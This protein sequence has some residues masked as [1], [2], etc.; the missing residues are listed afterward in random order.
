[1]CQLV[2]CIAA[3]Q[4]HRRLPLRTC[5]SQQ[6]PELLYAVQAFEA[7]QFLALHTTPLYLN[8]FFINP[9]YHIR[10]D[11]GS[12]QDNNKMMAG[13]FKAVIGMAPAFGNLSFC[14]LF[15]L[16]CV[17]VSPSIGN[18]KYASFVID[19]NT[20][21]VLHATNADT[22][23]YP[24]SLTKMM[25][26]YMIFD[27]LR[28]GKWTLNTK[29]KITRRAAIQPASKLGLKVGSTITVR[30]AILALV[31]K[32]ANDVAT[33]VA[34][35]AAG[36]ERA[37]A[38]QMTSKARE[39]G[40]RR[41]TF[42]NASGLPHRGQ[43]STARDMATLARSLIR[44]HQQY[45]HFFSTRKFNFKDRTYGNHNKLLA[46]YDGTD[47]IK[48]G[49][50]NASGYNL[51]A[52]AVR[53]N[54]RLIGVVFGGRSS[55]HRNR[56]MKILLDKGYGIINGTRQTVI[57]NSQKKPKDPIVAGVPNRKNRWGIQVGAYAK[58][59]QAFNAATKAVAMIPSL[60]ENGRV[61][62]VPLKRKKGRPLHRARIVDLTKKQAYQTCRYL[63]KRN[64][65]CMELT[66]KRPVEVASND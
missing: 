5:G 24:A 44:D 37:F 34:I 26:S 33:A 66:V 57:A 10:I 28:S 40:M 18:A 9:G 59:K 36:S 20:G 53:S 45:Y 52:S 14:L 63:K 39:L 65:Q 15:S 1:M 12:V 8:R 4:K 23:N 31:T 61:N 60:L 55:K 22:R 13:R 7:G 6:K 41:T 56:Q 2:C 43:M 27:K 3:L 58:Q 54:R 64:Q 51:V 50:I 48:T 16:F 25:T 17:V 62:I 19:A 46:S 11:E 21:Q 42:R 47:G 30:N 38:L 35:N 49:Y 32:S 29:L